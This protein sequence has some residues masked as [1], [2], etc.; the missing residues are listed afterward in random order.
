MQAYDTWKCDSPSCH[1]IDTDS[2]HD[3]AIERL[4]D[5]FQANLTPTLKQ[6]IAENYELDIDVCGDHESRW[7]TAK[8]LGVDEL[9]V[10]LEYKFYELGK[11]NEAQLDELERLD[12]ELYYPF[13][14]ELFTELIKSEDE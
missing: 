13:A 2:Y 14:V 5:E 1:E 9:F 3:E 11:L 10:D 8:Y 6:Y 7:E 4:E 12:P